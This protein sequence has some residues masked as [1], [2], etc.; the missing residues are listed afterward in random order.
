MPGG[1]DLFSNLAAL[2]MSLRLNVGIT[3]GRPRGG[4]C[5]LGKCLGA[6]PHTTCKAH[7][8]ADPSGACVVGQR[9]MMPY[10]IQD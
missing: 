6:G 7:D 2:A 4:P 5:P 3:C 9:H 8:R 1:L 10:H